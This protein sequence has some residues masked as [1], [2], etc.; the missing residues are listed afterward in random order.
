MLA[1]AVVVFREVLEAALIVTVILAA[2]KGVRRN[3]FYIAGGVGTGIFGSWLVAFFTNQLASAFEGNGQDLFNAGVMFAVVALLTWHIVWMQ[4][5][6]RQLVAEMKEV[7]F[8][9][10]TGHKSL[11]V[12]GAVVALAVLREGSE[13]VLFMQGLAASGQMGNMLGGFVL[14][15]AL[16]V[17]AGCV[18]YLGFLKLSVSKL[19]TSTNFLLMLIAAGMAARGAGLLIQAGYI[20]ALQDPV[21]DTSAILSDGST[22][23]KFLGALIGYIAA[24]SAMQMLFYGLTLIGITLLIKWQ[25]ASTPVKAQS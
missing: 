16:G 17:A 25:R 19:F 3:V 1:T 11:M 6:G 23:G 9:V 4:R 21:W 14:G 22:L 12:L 2:T 10:R 5:H 8:E 24:P 7:G 18:L 20:P 13:V 15:T